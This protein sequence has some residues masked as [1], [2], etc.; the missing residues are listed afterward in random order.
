MDV[1]ITLPGGSRVTGE[2][3]AGDIRCAGRL[4]ECRRKTGF[5]HVTATGSLGD[6]DIATGT[7]E[8]HLGEVVRG[9]VAA[10]RRRRDRGGAREHRVKGHHDPS[11]VGGPSV[12]RRAPKT[13]ATVDRIEI[14]MY[15]SE[16]RY[17]KR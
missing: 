16:Y 7:G 2:L 8:V 12:R 13:R 10:P 9:T 5:G 4:G 14:P 17:A 3:Q 11:G 1:S 6:A 15:I